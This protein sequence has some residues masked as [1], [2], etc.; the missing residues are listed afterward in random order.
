VFELEE[1]IE[2]QL[3]I[4]L[5]DSGV[6]LEEAHG[7]ARRVLR[8]MGFGD[9][10]EPTGNLSGGW[11][12]R[13]AIAREVVLEPDLLLLDE[14]TNHLDLEGILDLEALLGQARFAFVAVS[15]D[16][17]FLE[18]VARRMFELDRVYPQGLLEV[19]GTYSD[20]LDRREEVRKN[21]V[22]YQETLQ[23]RAR[24]EVEWLRRGPKARTTK[25]KARIETAGELLQELAEVRSRT[26][27][28][29]VAG[30]DFEGSGRKTKRLLE[31]RGITKRFGTRKVL[32][33]VDLM[34]GPGTR[35]GVLG[36]NGSGKTTLLS[37]LA[38]EL[39]PD[40][41][42]IERA[43]TLKTV[44]FEQSRE[45]LDRELTLRRALAPEGDAVVYQDREQHV[46]AWA[47]RFLFRAEQLDTRVARLSG[48]EQARI[49]IARLM[50]R[51]ADLL[52]LDEP[53]N[54]LDTA[55]LEVLEESLLEFPGAL[56]LVTHDR[57]LLDRVATT[58]LALDENGRGREF[59][60][61]EQWQ[62]ERRR[63]KATASA[64][65]AA[66]PPSTPGSGSPKK[67]IKKLSYQEEREWQSMESAIVEGEAEVERLR[68]AAEDPRIQSDALEVQRRYSA[69]AEAQRRGEARYARWAELEAKRGASG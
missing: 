64:A 20:L 6:D 65:P 52:I 13:L 31:A 60:D 41:G 58:I 59:A 51:P 54:D 5:T 1:S 36:P 16:R 49:L 30:I 3:L 40:S 42:T 33:G 35:I 43:P 27:T 63:P 50:L 68:V 18:H 24:R 66:A 8:R 7:R 46:A 39:K 56:V 10:D 25:S 26:A 32:T 48:G 4:A 45:T 55:T 67:A 44:L 61:L 62:S 17:W 38:G 29:G 57:Y 2:H 11:R 22:E 53:T 34:L 69:L 21:Q 47:R 37:I 12:K 19:A 15:H 9:P 23:N 28:R 14:P